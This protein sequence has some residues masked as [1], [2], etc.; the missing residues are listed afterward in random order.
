MPRTIRE[1]EIFPITVRELQV[2]RIVDITPGMRRITLSGA[3]LGPFTAGGLAHPAFRSNGFDDDVRLYFAYPGD[4]APVLPIQKDGT[5]ESPKDRRPLSR[6]YTIR[7]WDQAA[8]ELD[9]DFVTHA[10]G[11]ATTWALRCS[12]GDP[13]HLA[14]PAHSSF[15]PGGVDWM[16]VAG[17]E[18]ALPAIARLLE[19]APPEQRIQVFVEVAERAHEQ[20]LKTDAQVTITYL[21]RNGAAPGSTTL[22]ADAVRA[23]QWW[24]GVGFAW[25]AGETMSIKPIRRFLHEERGMPKEHIEV[26]GYWRPGEVVTLAEDPAVPDSDQ[27]DEPF[28]I[29]HEMGELLPPFALRA[30]VTLGIPEQIIRGVTD[31]PGLASACGADRTALRRLMRYLQALDVVHQPSAG[32]YGLTHVGELLTNDFVVDVLDTDGV[33]GRQQLAFTG[34]LDS[35]RTGRAAY[36][37]VFGRSFA[38]DHAGHEF[39]AS[40]QEQMAKYGPYLAPA[41]AEDEAIARTGTLTLRG[42]G[43]AVIAGIL[44]SALPGLRITIAG[45]P[46][47]VA[48]LRRDLPGS[49]PDAAVG[50]R[51]DVVEASVFEVAPAAD[52]VLLVRCLDE[53]ADADAA[54][55]L[56]QAAAGLHPGGTVVVVEFPLDEGSA[57]DHAFE[58][59]IKH[60]V[61]YGTGHRT[62]AENRALFDQAG[63][64][65]V[66]VRTVGWGFRLYELAAG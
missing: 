27:I 58:E 47:T 42:D 57:D 21:H 2:K 32:R 45:L 43:V 6:N 31:I 48:Y 64:R 36:P 16:L 24:P 60:L 55:V 29:L 39:E 25:V 28:D 13:P 9:I 23:A 8:G 38:A 33:I 51:I 63:L 35:V 1:S 65:L 40:L 53:H 46:S 62:D 61:M 44:A 22:L 11:V 3:Q 12:A 59:D 41:L 4:A 18:T 14:G 34:L 10:T 49:I 7:R 50:E 54:H 5:I 26:T 15:L 19:T 56:R 66:A 20:E 30:A 37:L 17:D 52:R